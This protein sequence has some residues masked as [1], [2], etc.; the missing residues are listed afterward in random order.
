VHGRHR[1]LDTDVV[2]GARHADIL[3]ERDDGLIEM[4][5]RKFDDLMATEPSPDF[6]YPR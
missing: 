1:Y 4:D 6:P 2:W 3:S 5:V